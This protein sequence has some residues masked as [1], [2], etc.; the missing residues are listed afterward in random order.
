MILSYPLP[1]FGLGVCVSP[2]PVPMLYAFLITWSLCV[3]A[4]VSAEAHTWAWVKMLDTDAGC[5]PCSPLYFWRQGFSVET[6]AG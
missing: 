3:W 1:E 5:L 4:H 2:C 6:R